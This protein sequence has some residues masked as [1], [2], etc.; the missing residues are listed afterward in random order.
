MWE[1]CEC[2]FCK[3]IATWKDSVTRK[4][5]QQ[6][7]A[8]QRQGK[9]KLKPISPTFYWAQLSP[10]GVM[11]EREQLIKAHTEADY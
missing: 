11:S 6:K 8:S 1:E 9:I 7:I 3:K 4:Q 2:G 10:V 5:P